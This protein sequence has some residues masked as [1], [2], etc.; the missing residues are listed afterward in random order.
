MLHVDPHQ[1]YTAEQV[2]KHS[3]ITCRDQLP[4]YQLNRQ[5]APHLVKVNLVPVFQ[6]LWKADFIIVNEDLMISELHCFPGGH[7]CHI[8]CTESQDISACVR[9][10]RSFQLS[11]TAK[12]EKANINRLIDPLGVLSQSGKRGKKSNKW[13]SM[14]LACDLKSIYKFLLHYLNSFLGGRDDTGPGG[15]MTCVY[16]KHW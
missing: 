5:D 13:L 3:W 2:L 7:G 15:F 14:C 9:A 11:S 10:C 8:F 6:S 12:H 1:R 4:H 16:R